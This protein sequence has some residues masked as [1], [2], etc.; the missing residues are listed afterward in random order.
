MPIL[1]TL[2]AINCPAAQQRGSFLRIADAPTFTNGNAPVSE[3]MATGTGSLFRYDTIRPHATRLDLLSGYGGANANCILSGSNAG[4][5]LVLSAGAGLTLNIKAGHVNAGG[6]VELAADSTIA[7][8]DATSR[9]WIWL[10]QNGTLSYTTTISP[11]A[12]LPCLLGS[13]VTAGGVITAVDNSGVI[14]LQAG[15]LWRSTADPGIP[16][17]TPPASVA[18]MVTRTAFASFTWDGTAHRQIYTPSVT[19]DPTALAEGM[20]WIRNDLVPVRAISY[21][22]GSKIFTTPTATGAAPVP[23]AANVLAISPGAAAIAYTTPTTLT[24]FKGTPL[25]RAAV[26]F[27]NITQARIISQGDGG[28]TPADPPTI[29]VRYSLNSGT[30]WLPLDGGTGPSLTHGT[31]TQISAWAS[32]AAGAKTACLLAVFAQSSIGTASWNFGTITVQAK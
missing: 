12:T 19:A 28:S 24:E 4:N 31:L 11:P 7:V 26:D 2:L 25:Y 5:E 16:T 18:G 13:C 6:I 9:V 29:S 30:T 14:Y 10:Q 17:D 21:I 32:I 20:N 27:T 15:V 1:T 22:G 23:I 3:N 8:P